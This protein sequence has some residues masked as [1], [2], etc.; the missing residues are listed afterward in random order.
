[1]HV[2]APQSRSYEAQKQG[3]C[4]NMLA[5][6]LLGYCLDNSGHNEVI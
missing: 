1:M 2:S 6:Q 3:M 5:R 4:D